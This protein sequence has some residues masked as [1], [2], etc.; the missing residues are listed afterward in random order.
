MNAEESE[1][2]GK[3][4]IENFSEAYKTIKMKLLGHIMRTDNEDSL[5]Q[6][7]LKKCIARATEP[8]KH[9]VGK[10]R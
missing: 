5:R 9:R 3:T 6:V 7:T 2:T 4:A 8:G 1:E 10:P